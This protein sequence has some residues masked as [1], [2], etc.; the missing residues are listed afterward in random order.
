M[1]DRKLSQEEFDAEMM[2]RALELAERGSGFVR[3]NPLIVSGRGNKGLREAGIEVV[4]GV[5]EKK[6]RIL[7]ES[8]VHSIQTGTPYVTAKFAQSLDG[9]VAL[10]SGESQWITG[11]LARE[12]TH[13]LRAASD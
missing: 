3:P 1:G 10:P 11:E 5:R 2:D 4:V 6:A 7:N 8:Y 9:F 13:R 12:R